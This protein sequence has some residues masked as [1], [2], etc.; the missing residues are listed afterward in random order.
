MAKHSQG[1]VRP[2]A[3]E[4]TF[5]ISPFSISLVQRALSLCTLLAPEF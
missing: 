3:Q 4:S 2:E 1:E 5:N